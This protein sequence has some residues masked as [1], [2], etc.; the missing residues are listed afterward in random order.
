LQLPLSRSL[1]EKPKL[2]AFSGSGS[3]LNVFLALEVK[4]GA[5]KAPRR[6]RIR[7]DGARFLG[8]KSEENRKE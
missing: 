1:A 6:M 4:N 5:K 2:P 8:E 7:G 3:Y